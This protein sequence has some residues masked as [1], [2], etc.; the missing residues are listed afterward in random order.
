M[1]ITSSPPT[2]PLTPARPV[3]TPPRRR[4]KQGNPLLLRIFG[5]AVLIHVIAI[6]ILAKFGA[7]KKV[8]KITPPEAR[9]RTRRARTIRRPRSQRS[10]LPRAPAEATTMA[11]R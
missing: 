6:P 10:R 11:P 8:Q 3:A 4:R 2:P 7:F 5:I 1:A 9:T